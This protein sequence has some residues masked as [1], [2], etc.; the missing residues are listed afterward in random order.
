MGRTI[1]I[2]TVVP[3]LV[4]DVMFN[5]LVPFAYFSFFRIED[6]GLTLGVIALLNIGRIALW[7]P[8][9]AQQMRPAEKYQRASAGIPSE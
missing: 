6:V 9:L 1:T 5:L 3:L 2:K 8:L 7:V 4:V